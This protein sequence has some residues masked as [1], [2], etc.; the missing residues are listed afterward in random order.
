MLFLVLKKVTKCLL[1]VFIKFL[2][3]NLL[4]A[5]NKHSQKYLDIS[6]Q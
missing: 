5:A 3:L 4:F 1:E 2:N 6:A